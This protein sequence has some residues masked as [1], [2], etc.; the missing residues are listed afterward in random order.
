MQLRQ[1]LL[2]CLTAFVT[3]A[4]HA[5]SLSDIDKKKLPADPQLTL[6]LAKISKLEPYVQYFSPNWQAP[7]TKEEAASELRNASAI[8]NAFRQKDAANEELALLAGLIHTYAY[9]LDLENASEAATKDFQDAEKLNPTDVR[10]RW[11][12]ADH[13]CETTEYLKQGMESMLSLGDAAPSNAL[14]IAFWEDYINCA[15][16]TMMPAHALRASS[17]LD[18]QARGNTLMNAV[19]GKVR[20]N[21][22]SAKTYKPEELW[23]TYDIPNG[24]QFR[25]YACGMSFE[26]PQGWKP[27]FFP[28]KDGKCAVQIELPP[29]KGND[30]DWTPNIFLLVMPPAGNEKFD[31]FAAKFETRGVKQESAELAALCP[32]AKCVSVD[33]FDT[34]TY[35]TAGGG[36]GWILMF[37][38]GQPLNPGIALETEPVPPPA[39][40]DGGFF[41]P[42]DYL[43]RFPGTLNYVILLDTAASI[44]PQAKLEFSQFVKTLRVD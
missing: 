22:S 32:V 24:V 1:L 5:A 44:L 18:P 34:K 23:I 8:V 27:K 17:N 3:C 39:H 41:H 12:L 29:I 26:L 13:Q 19:L 30:G 36:H 6:A 33:M 25:T 20:A 14:P 16:E 7:F 9:N 2:V 10:P 4:A 38:R 11:F 42:P 35:P 31:D 43:F 28:I 21:A 37:Q 15:G 40:G